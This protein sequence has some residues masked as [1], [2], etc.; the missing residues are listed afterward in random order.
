MATDAP[1]ILFATDLLITDYSSIIF[2]FATLRRPML[3]FA[4]DLDTYRED[5][6]FYEPYEELVPGRIVRTMPELIDAIRREDY[7]ADR[8]PAFAERHLAHLDGR[9]TDRVIDQLILPGL[10]WSRSR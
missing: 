10:R 7:A 6:D 5:V 8:V 3:F 4:P 9:A 2:E 1:D